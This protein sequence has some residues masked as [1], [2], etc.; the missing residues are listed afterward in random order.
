MADLQVQIN[1]IFII[2]NAFGFSTILL[3]LIFPHAKVVS[4]DAGCEGKDNMRGI[5]LTN[6]ICK[7]HSLNAIVEYG[8][9]PQNTQEIINKHFGENKID[10]CFIDG[11]HTN[12]QLLLDFEESQKYCH[13]N[14]LYFMHDVINW[15]MQESFQKIKQLIAPTHISSILWR[16]QSGMVLSIPKDNL[17][18]LF[19]LNCFTENQSN[20]DKIGEY[21]KK[22]SQISRKIA[23][24]LPTKIRQ[25]I[26]KVIR[27]T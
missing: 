2:G 9:S 13:S 7:K 21:A 18:L 3:S 20:I 16:T 10:L 4:I 24:L 23:R 11:L 15:K 12:E 14:T 19:Y 5:E 25:I 22:E 6:I 26:K 1:N 17:E 27:Q 8:F